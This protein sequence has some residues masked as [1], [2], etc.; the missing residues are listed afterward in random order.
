MRTSQEGRELLAEREGV[1][2]RAYRDS[3]GVLTIGVGHT[4]SAGPP[5]P[6]S[7]MT[8]TRA[9]VMALFAKDLVKYEKTVSDSLARAVN[10]RQFDAC[11]SLCYNVGQGGFKRSS[12][13]KRINVG[14]FDGAA[15]AFLMWNKPREI[16][17]RRR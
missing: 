9:E 11:V 13:V 2:L 1:R 4:A 7:G 6:K 14:D 16:L 8:L 3:V 17:S 10:Q 15:R 12:V 5:A